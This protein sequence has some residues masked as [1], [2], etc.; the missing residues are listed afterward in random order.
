MGFDE[1]GANSEPQ[2]FQRRSAIARGWK[3]GKRD[4]KKWLWLEMLL[5]REE[6]KPSLEVHTLSA[7]NGMLLNDKQIYVGL[8]LRK[9][10]DMKE[11]G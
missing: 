1:V 3:V 10:Q 5:M 6:T 2:I 4:V 7:M 9:Q 11:E 8:L